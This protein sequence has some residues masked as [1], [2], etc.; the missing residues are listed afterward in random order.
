MS[1]EL[2]QYRLTQVEQLSA[3]HD[4]ELE[5]LQNQNAVL[6]AKL[7]GLRQSHRAVIGG[8]IALGVSV[9]GSAAAIIVLL[10]GHP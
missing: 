8:F 5:A 10:G 1:N 7:E 2:D 4:S 3:Q 9:I 6:E